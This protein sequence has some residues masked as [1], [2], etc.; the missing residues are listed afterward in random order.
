MPKESICIGGVFSEP[1]P[2]LNPKELVTIV[3]LIANK[4]I[5]AN[6]RNIAVDITATLKFL[7]KVNPINI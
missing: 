6:K 1:E 4:L 7:I 5:V 3:F 2:K